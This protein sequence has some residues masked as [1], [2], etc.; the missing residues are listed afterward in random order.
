MANTTNTTRR[1]RTLPNAEAA[2]AAEAEAAKTAALAAQRQN[3]SETL[4][5]LCADIISDYINA[6][7]AIEAA[8]ADAATKLESTLSRLAAF[9]HEHGLTTEMIRPIIDAALGRFY[10]KEQIAMG[11]GGVASKRTQLARAMHPKVAGNINTVLRPW[12]AAWEAEDKAKADE[13]AKAKAENRDAKAVP[14]PLREK[15]ENRGNLVNQALTLAIGVP[16]KVNA[17]GVVTK[18]GVPSVTCDT[19]AEVVHW[20]QAHPRQARSPQQPVAVVA[21]VTPNLP[22]DATDRQKA[23]ARVTGLINA[24]QDVAKDYPAA[25]ALFATVLEALR[26][27]TSDKLLPSTPA[28]SANEPMTGAAD[29][30]DAIDPNTGFSPKQMAALR[31][32]LR[33]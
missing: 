24:V 23:E 29:L 3:N 31:M 21:T 17:K 33:G 25:T 12:L 2:K 13:L 5:A 16:A 26:Q 7:K 14:Q 15:F 20:V 22:A 8:K 27:C 6:D 18:E 19:P 4:N 28:P 9:S 30:D 10:T 32:M 1:G 11:V